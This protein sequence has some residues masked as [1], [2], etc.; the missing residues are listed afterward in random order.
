MLL[1]KPL[2]FT[3]RHPKLTN[4]SVELTYNQK[5]IGTLTR[6]FISYRSAEASIDGKRYNFYSKS[7]FSP[8]F[9]IEDLSSKEV[10]ADYTISGWYIFNTKGTLNFR[11]KE[12]YYLKSSFLKSVSS[13]TNLNDDLIAAFEGQGFSFKT[14]GTVKLYEPLTERGKILVLF[15]IFLVLNT[16]HGA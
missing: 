14:A 13:W 2:V 6:K 5:I 3:W 16:T 4:N 7:F 1:K 8:K 15:G 10:I 12:T 11:D 9:E